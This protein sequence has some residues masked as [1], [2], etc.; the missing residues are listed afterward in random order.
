MM[1]YL[2]YSDDKANWYSPIVKV[3]I[4]CGTLLNKTYT[5]QTAELEGS[6]DGILIRPKGSKTSFMVPWVRVVFLELDEKY[7]DWRAKDDC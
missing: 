5:T 4:D 1:Y 7:M 3:Q 2:L 6:V